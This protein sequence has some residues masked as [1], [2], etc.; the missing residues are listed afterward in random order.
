MLALAE[1]TAA[2]PLDAQMRVKREQLNDLC[3]SEEAKR[4]RRDIATLQNDVLN[5]VRLVTD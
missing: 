2:P 3:R 4:G 5:L 1:A